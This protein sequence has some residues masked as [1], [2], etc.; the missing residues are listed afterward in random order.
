MRQVKLGRKA[1]F[2]SPLAYHWAVQVGD[3]WYEIEGGKTNQNSVETNEGDAAAS[4]AGS[5]GGELVGETDATDEEINDW[6]EKWLDRNPDYETL[7][8][9]CQKFAYEFMAW[10]T[11]GNFI[12]SHRFNA[13][14]SK[15]GD[16]KK[17]I[18]SFAR[19]EDGNAIARLSTT[20][21]RA[22][23]AYGS[24]S[25]RSIHFQAQAVAGPG[26]GAWV[27]ASGFKLEASFGNALGAHFEPNVNTGAGIRNGNLDVH[28][29]GF[30]GK[31]GADGIELDTPLGGVNACSVM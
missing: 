23:L 14:D 6:I 28:L 15:Y 11:D 19:K 25:A 5:L 3:T 4:S 8:V 24:A 31:I 10:L 1:M 26:L 17:G 18:R 9:N 2:G 30:G 13:A 21:A 20:E 7:S 16:V 12:C 27:D 22:S 29:A